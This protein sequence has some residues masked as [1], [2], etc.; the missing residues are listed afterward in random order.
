MMAIGGAAFMLVCHQHLE[1]KQLAKENLQLKQ[2]KKDLKKRRK[3]LHPDGSHDLQESHVYP[4]IGHVRSC[5][6]DCQSTPRQPGL[7]PACRAELILD[8]GTSIHTLEGLEEHS[9]VWVHI[10]STQQ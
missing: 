9:H 2:S 7:A 6:L 8:K 1:K 5:F 4:P 3:D 10:Y